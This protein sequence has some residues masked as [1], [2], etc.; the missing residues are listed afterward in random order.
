MYRAQSKMKK[1][2]QEKWNSRLT[3]M[4]M[5]RLTNAKPRIDMKNPFQ[6]KHLYK[7]C[8]KEQ[9]LEGKSD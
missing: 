2:L 6:F 7:K 4:H 5:D 8:K 3:D 9:L 1:T